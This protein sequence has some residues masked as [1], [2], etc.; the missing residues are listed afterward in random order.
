MIAAVRPGLVLAF[1]LIALMSA[2][3]HPPFLA[4]QT[5][6]SDATLSSLTVND[7]TSDVVLDPVFTSATTSYRV[8]I[9]HRGETITVA[10]V[11]TDTNATFDFLDRSD[12]ALTDADPDTTGFQV[13]APVGESE[14]MVKVTAQDGVTTELYEVAVQRN[15]A[16]FAGWTPTRDVN[17]LHTDNSSAKGIWSDGTTVWVA[18][19]EDDKLYAY[20]LSDGTR[21]DGTGS[22]TDKEL[23]F[24]AD[25][26]SAKGIWSDSTTVWVADD[27]DDKLY[28][29][30]L[31]DGTRQDGTGSTTDKE[32]SLHADNADPWGIWSDG[33]T[34]WV[35]DQID[36][37]LYAYALSGGAR[38]QTREFALSPSQPAGVWS[39]GNTIWVAVGVSPFE[40]VN[41]YTLDFSSGT[42]G[43]NHG[44]IDPD[45]S[46]LEL[47]PE[48]TRG[49]AGGIWSDGKEAMW[50]STVSPASPKLHSYN[51]SPSEAGGVALSALT[52]NHGGSAVALRPSF[53]LST[54][55]YWVSVPNEVN[56]VTVSATVSTGS[57]IAYVG[58]DGPLEDADANTD[59]HQVG[60]DVGTTAVGVLVTA[61]D[62]DALI[63]NVFVERD[64]ARFRGWTPTR[65]IHNLRAAGNTHARGISSNGTTIWVAD[66]QD[67]QLYAYTLATDVRDQSK[68]ITLHADNDDPSGMWS[69]GTT[70]WVSESYTSGTSE[71][72][73]YAYTLV[74][75]VRDQSKD[76]TLHADNAHPRG[77]WS[78]GTIIWVADRV[79][80]KIYAYN[81]SDSKRQ[82]GT[83]STSNR[84]F[85]LTEFGG[86]VPEGIW[87]DGTTM[88]A[89]NSLQSSLY[90]YTLASGARATANDIPL[91]I[92]NRSPEGLWS[93]GSTIWVSE[94]N[95]SPRASAYY[96]VFSYTLPPSAQSTTTLSGLT[97]NPSPP[98]PSF[99]A[100]LRPE[101]TFDIDSYRVAV[102]NEASTVTVTATPKESDAEV[103]YL[104]GDGETLTDADTG[105]DGLQVA[106]AVGATLIEIRVA[107]GT[108]PPSLYA[109][110]VERDSTELYGW[111]PTG[112]FNTLLKDNPA[113]RNDTVRGEWGTE[114]TLYVTPQYAA[115]IFAYNRSDGSRDESKDIT[116][117]QSTIPFLN[118]H[119]AGIWS[120]GSTLWSLDYFWGQS[121]GTESR[122]STGKLF[123][124]NISAGDTYGERDTTKE[125]GLHLHPFQSVRGIWSNGTTVWVSDWRAAKLFAYTLATGAKD[126]SKD[127]TLTQDNAA[128]QG[129]WSDGTTIWVADWEDDKFYAYKMMAGDEFGARDESKEFDLAPD[130]LY[131]RDV[132]SD[133]ETM[134]VPDAHGPAGQKLY[135]YNMIS[136]VVANTAPTFTTTADF[137][138][139]ENELFSFAVTAEDAD[140]GDEVTYAITG[141]ADL[142]LFTIGA[143]SG[144]MT[145]AITPDYE[146]PA[147]ADSNN[148]Y[149]VTVTATGGTGD[150]ALTTDQAITVTVDDVNEPPS[151]PAAP[152][153]SAVSDSSDSL[154]V[155]WTA[156]DNSGKPAIESYDLQYRKGTTGNFAD[157]PQ[158]VTDTTTIIGGLDADSLYQVQVRASND[159]GDG[160]WSSPGSG[161][162]N[163]AINNPPEF[164]ADSATREVAENSPAGTDVGDP[165]TAT[166]DDNDTLTY[167]LEG[168]AAAAFAI[169]SASGQIRTKAG[170]TYDHESQ[171]EYS[172]TVK[173]D[174]GNSGTDTI[175][176]TIDITDV[177]EPPS[178]P[179]APTVS[180][181]SG[182]S[183]SLEV[184]WTAPDNSG[185]PNIE[186]YDLQYRKGTTGN[187]ADG[188]QDVTD[189]TT[190]IG[191]LDADSLYQVQ[192]R[193]TND[194]G[195][196][197]WSTAGSRT[198]GAQANAAPVFP[199]DTT[200]RDV[201]ENSPAGTNVGDP[202]T[203]MD[204]DGDTLTY[205]LEGTDA[206]SFDIDSES[207]QIQTKSGVTY[208]YETKEGYSVT[209]KA[210]DGNGG[211]AT[212]AVTINLLD[213]PETA[214]I[215]LAFEIEGLQYGA[216]EQ[217]EDAG[218]V[219]VG[220]RAETEGNTPPAED[221]EVILRTVDETAQAPSDYVAATLTYTFR[222]A[223]FVLENGQYVQT[224]SHDIEIVDDEIVEKVEYFELDVDQDALPGHVTAPSITTVVIE[225]QEDD[226]TT[227]RV[228][229]VTV[230]EGDDVV[231]TFTIDREVAFDFWFLVS[232]IEL[233]DEP[234]LDLF[235]APLV[236]FNLGQ[237]LQ[238]LTVRTVED[239]VVEPN[240][241]VELE[242]IR[243]LLFE[244]IALDE[245][246]RPTVT[247][248][249]DDVPE[250]A[251][252]VDPA[253]IAEAGGSATLTVRTGGVTFADAQTIEL[254][255]AGGSATLGTDFTVADADGNPLTAPYALTL[256]VGES[257]VTATITAVEDTD[258]D[259]GEHIQVSATRNGETLGATQTLTITTGAP[260]GGGD[261]QLPGA[262]GP[263]VEVDDNGDGVVDA[264]PVVTLPLRGSVSYRVRPGRCEGYK[265]L[266]VQGMSDA[267][268]GA[269]PHIPVE[270]SQ[271]VSP[272]PCMGEDDPGEWQT[273]TL[274]VPADLRQEL[275]LVT[276]FEASVKHS[277]YYRRYLTGPSSRLLHWGHLV[278]AR[279]RAPETLAPVGSLTVAP[280]ARDY[281][282]VTWNAVPGA[283]D[284]QVQWRWGP[285]EKYGRVHS[286]EGSIYSREKRTEETAYT[287]PISETVPTTD[288]GV[289]RSQRIT[290][291]VRP[292][293]SDG[294]AVGPWRE[295]S[296]AERTEVRRV[297]A[298]FS[299][300]D[301][302]GS[303]PGL[304]AAL[305]DG[306]TVEL[307]DPDGGAY[308]IRAELVEGEL[309]GSVHLEL[310]GKKRARAT[311]DEAP[312][313]LAGGEGMALPAGSYKLKAK[314]YGGPNRTYAVQDTLE[315]SF[316]V[317]AAA[318]GE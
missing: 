193:A 53:H 31:S 30:S 259:D 232:E 40:R 317:R 290:V 6:S 45:K 194:E 171:S 191:G 153:V 110:I 265:T 49:P 270:A 76:I 304:L 129:I 157:G 239:V 172:V 240:E 158:D 13:N 35:A 1:V 91:A 80:R 143:T 116:I 198:T 295:A 179:A 47:E 204:D 58:D 96:R 303:S 48:V 88:W 37:R 250:W 188:P 101:F 74:T 298:G 11:P 216:T 136:Q 44:Q 314:A 84:E 307:A 236:T 43:P 51:I 181:V 70:I 57:T 119:K 164:A 107:K 249:N 106:V 64:S 34:F 89:I 166:D 251:L 182:T 227:V 206:A 277:V 123:A 311:D 174:D 132:W 264:D 23:S 150:R 50:V 55:R 201:P 130:N 141:G 301:A 217:E 176:V 27:E 263:V 41:A 131:P 178:A 318:S 134:Y 99:S 275:L 258:D 75:G 170:M 122:D 218:M 221:F 159:E 300:L 121:D 266:V 20:S 293:D 156:P 145:L 297:L 187:F 180:A 114:T 286:Q 234:D 154:E 104:S 77:I 128:A 222:A 190:I 276:P 15:S 133:G 252:S 197:A 109:V 32:L 60:V 288:E 279:V 287:I 223:D 127:I 256:A 306:A 235:P 139:N 67:G 267:S 93:N 316:T 97:V 189:T 137:S 118:G 21:Q 120:N 10:A 7:G 296:L 100:N 16:R 177:A 261:G 241:T 71:F 281:P 42:A 28:A 214:A 313:L 149:L 29:Y 211:T 95:R 205:T 173:A 73:I 83:D 246:P 142:A 112:D 38:S 183:D 165:V 299:L 268:E 36:F 210:D 14:F 312:Y 237:T 272:M 17:P 72:K 212:I 85:E 257:A 18:D 195:D 103:A 69:D 260:S 309:A 68:D 5:P 230:D 65:D 280:E 292:Y 9:K 247:I 289:E 209:V 126:A 248:L 147:D 196:G 160:D 66:D 125:F 168:T 151:A 185:K 81:L 215:T 59:E 262:A 52:V 308:A 184:T 79:D 90:A 238:T 302:D 86:G 255:F 282:R 82:D 192:V 271:E 26:D 25:N 2:A 315:V 98:V 200:T 12:A 207:G 305:T 225:I 54:V 8:A 56:Q 208:D 111:T 213:V 152:T 146:N 278:T 219:A 291:R 62:G 284:Y 102:P 175:A 78:N 167:T 117:D 224:V 162:T 105:T 274:A 254:D 46:L 161:S 285:D 310:T 242:L 244:L 220:L 108:S 243:N 233:G 163:A 283:T 140:A 294:L 155:T 39:D 61:A 124:Y 253:T 135:S 148:V 138:T 92:S 63:H 33:T 226:R 115:K 144:Q 22:T 229:S 203:A 3:L 231:L 202:V 186:S 94:P 87:S 199:A 169:V 4:A 19:D 245:D 228:E 269:P 24:H 113:L 273:V